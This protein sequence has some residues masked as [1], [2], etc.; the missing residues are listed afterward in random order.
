MVIS[1]EPSNATPL[2]VRAVASLVAVAAFPLVLWLPGAF[3]P[4]RLMFAV[5]SNETPPMVRAVASLV[6][7]SACATLASATAAAVIRSS[8]RSPAANACA[9][10]PSWAR[11]TVSTSP[12]RAVQ[13]MISS[14]PLAL[15]TVSGNQSAPVGL[16]NL[17]PSPDVTESVVSPAARDDARRD[18]A[19]FL[20]KTPISALHYS[21][22]ECDFLHAPLGGGS[23]HV[24][25]VG[26]AGRASGQPDLDDGAEHLDAL[27]SDAGRFRRGCGV[28]DGV[29]GRQPALEIHVVV[30]L[31]VGT[32]ADGAE[33][34]SLLSAGT[35]NRRNSSVSRSVRMPGA[36]T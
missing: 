12:D 34:H 4:G 26:A 2:I 23:G 33:H 1:A 9:A 35:M 28:L 19:L 8:T 5:P 17:E 30:E 3:T 27:D 15:M 6:A 32:L 16:G 21:K 18:V 25:L 29:A 14:T 36:A 22:D 31:V 10:V 7:V 20:S 24:D 13:R 11:T